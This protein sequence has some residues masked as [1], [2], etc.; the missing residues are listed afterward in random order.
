MLQYFLMAEACNF[1]EEETLAQVFSCEFCEI[2]KNTFFTEHVWTT[3][4]INI[5]FANTLRPDENNLI[6]FLQQVGE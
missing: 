5:L 4:S 2:S 1:I 6:H 3:A